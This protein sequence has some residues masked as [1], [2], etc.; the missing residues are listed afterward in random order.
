MLLT[1]AQRCT[2]ARH[3]HGGCYV[4]EAVVVYMDIL[5]I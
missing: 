1:Q 2:L 3:V 4:N 5:G